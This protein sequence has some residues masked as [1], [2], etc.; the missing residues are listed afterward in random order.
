MNKK[1]KDTWISYMFMA[2]GI[3]GL[4]GAIFYDT[5]PQCIILILV[6]VFTFWCSYIIKNEGIEDIESK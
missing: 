1:K 5:I 6:S 3:L 2:V 4:F